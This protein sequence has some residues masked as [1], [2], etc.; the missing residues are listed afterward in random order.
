MDVTQQ[1]PRPRTCGECDKWFLGCLNGREKWKDPAVMPNLRTEVD[2][3]G[4][5][6][7]LCDAFEFFPMPDGELRN[8]RIVF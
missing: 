4:T 6:R 7:R 8:G 2:E 3:D 5:V 1:K